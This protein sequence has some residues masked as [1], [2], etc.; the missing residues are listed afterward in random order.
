GGGAARGRGDGQRGLLHEVGG[1]RVVAVHHDRGGG[2]ARVGQVGRVGTAPAAVAVAALGVLGKGHGR[3]RVVGASAG[4][5]AAGA[6]DDGQRVGRHHRQRDRTGRGGGGV[7]LGQGDGEG[8]ARR[9]RPGD[10]ASR[11]IDGEARG[12]VLRR[13]RRAEA[14]RAELVEEGLVLP[15]GLADRGQRGLRVD[16]DRGLLGSGGA[17]VV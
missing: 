12:H 3:A 16:R 2:E 5:G 10:G 11:G 17:V 15:D 8:A 6:V 13:Q 1:D 4:G 9:G 7:L 14:G